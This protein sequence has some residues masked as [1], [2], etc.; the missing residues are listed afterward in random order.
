[1]KK[2]M[3][4][5]TATLALACTSCGN[6]LY[7]VAGK[8]TYKGK[9]AAGATVFLRRQG[10]DPVNEHLIMGIVQG[11]GS[12]TLACGS[13]G[14]GAPPGEYDVL[15]EWKQG[16]NQAKGRPQK[17][18]DRLKGLYADPK[19]PRLHAVVKAE[20]NQLPPIELTDQE[21]VRKRGPSP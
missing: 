1:M 8:V 5:A 12:F 15:V 7:P 10:G 18:P 19:H 11:D 13:V 20:T 16:S 17:G 21:P 3:L 6:G 14:P 4:C 2:R 9:P